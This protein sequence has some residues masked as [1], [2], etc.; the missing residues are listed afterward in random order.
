MLV[1][2]GKNRQ[3][4]LLKPQ[5]IYIERQSSHW[6]ILF[7]RQRNSCPGLP[8]ISVWS[9]A[10]DSSFPTKNKKLIWKTD[11]WRVSPKIMM[12]KNPGIHTPQ[13]ILAICFLSAD[14]YSLGDFGDLPNLLHRH[15]N[16]WHSEHLEGWRTCAGGD[17]L[18]H[19]NIFFFGT[20][21]TLRG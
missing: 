12:W 6:E 20:L 14:W 2:A 1:R 17:M 15:Q 5:G 3:V 10:P 18:G 11:H 7:L 13:P 16:S 4:G 19:T 21:A 8:E 9:I